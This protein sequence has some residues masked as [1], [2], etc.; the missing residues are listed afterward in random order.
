MSSARSTNAF[1]DDAASV[2]IDDEPAKPP[3]EKRAP[4]IISIHRPARIKE[5]DGLRGI[6]ILMV[7]AFHGVF[8]LQP[9][10]KILSELLILG[11]LSWS[12]V[13]LFFVLSGFLIGGIL[14]DVRD[15]PNYFKT[16][17]LRRAYRILPLYTVVLVLFSLRFVHRAAGPL[18]SF[19]DS[20]IP[21]FSYLT[22]TQ[23]LW[24]AG[25]G[26]FGAGTMAVTWSLAVEEQFYLSAPLVLR[27]ITRERLLV[28]LLTIIGGAP[29]LRTILYLGFRQWRFADYVLMPCR[30]DALSL[31]V[32]VALLVRTPR[33]WKLVLENTQMLRTATWVLLAGLGVLTISGS[34]SSGSMATIGYSW[35]ACLY[36]CILLIAVAGASRR[37][38]YVLL[39]PVLMRLGT[40]AYATYL[41]HLPFMEATRRVLGLRFAYASEANQFWGGWLGI[42]LAL[43]FAMLSWKYIEQPLLRRGHAYQY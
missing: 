1:A 38:R 2:G 24:M 32:L 12:G 23:N 40:L 42:G 15:S 13:D 19:S 41:F 33:W 39:N 3:G 34:A 14:L 31:G 35:L 22:F 43:I 37:L 29:L 6:A 7:L 4:R 10:S 30:A 8:Q 25:L 18:G 16:F 28:V 5:L 11:R 9:S 17:Y 26:T 27:M 20:Q 21:W 36:A